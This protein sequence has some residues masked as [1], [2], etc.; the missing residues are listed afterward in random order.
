[1][2][3]Y[4]KLHTVIFTGG[5]K[6]LPDLVIHLIQ[7]TVVYYEALFILLMNSF[8]MVF[9]VTLQCSPQDFLKG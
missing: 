1:M 3:G 9:T 5:G 6:L 8:E 7:Y 2:S 4:N